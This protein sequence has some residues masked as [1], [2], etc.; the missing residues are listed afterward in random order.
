MSGTTTTDRAAGVISTPAEEQGAFTPG[1]WEVRHF[2]DGH[3]F[4]Y[5]AHIRSEFDA[6]V[7][8]CSGEKQAANARLIA[9]APDMLAALEA[10]VDC[11]QSI[12]ADQT[13]AYGRAYAAIAKAK[14]QPSKD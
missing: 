5:A 12:S 3:A 1:P 4:V 6:F 13:E 9:A 2:P 11:A 7:C 10:V 14:G 8:N